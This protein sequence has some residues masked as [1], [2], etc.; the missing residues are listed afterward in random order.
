[1][2]SKATNESHIIETHAKA[3]I[4]HA[5]ASLPQKSDTKDYGKDE[6]LIPDTKFEK[7]C[8][9][10]RDR[11]LSSI[12]NIQF[13]IDDL[14]WEVPGQHINF[15]ELAKIIYSHGDSAGGSCYEHAIVVYDYLSNKL[16]EAILDIVRLESPGDHVFVVI[17]Q[18]KINQQKNT[19][20]AYPKRFKDW[21]N[22]AYIVDAWTKITC[23][24]RNYPQEWENK[25]QKWERRGLKI[26]DCSPLSRRNTVAQHNKI[27]A[28]QISASH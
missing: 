27:S 12:N 2:E 28:S 25:M 7:Y 17:N 26:S 21:D 14:I 24:A 9:T 6:S 5:R 18:Q 19:I 22:N 8:K 3:A 10:A 1:M 23:P 20:G 13:Q 11:R 15:K 4:A 16:P